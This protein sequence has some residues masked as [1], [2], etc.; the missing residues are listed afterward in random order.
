MPSIFFQS[1][2]V[3]QDKYP[4]ETA[5]NAHV[6]GIEHKEDSESSNADRREKSVM[7]R[8]CDEKHEGEMVDF[9]MTVIKSFQHD[10]LGR[11][12]AEALR[13]KSIEPSKR[14]NN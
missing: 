9:K 1:I 8:H 6:R 11:Q 2:K 12:C 7:A 3:C 13:I 5:R 4:G 14:I 10:P